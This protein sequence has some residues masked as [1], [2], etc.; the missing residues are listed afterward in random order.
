MC[1][2]LKV[3]PQSGLQE[4]LNVVHT[5]VGIA[6]LGEKVYANLALYVHNVV[7]HASLPVCSRS[8]VASSLRKGPTS[9]IELCIV[10]M[11]LGHAPPGKFAILGLL[12]SFDAISE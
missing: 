2:V 5:N 12:R 3:L 11:V 4:A 10:R 9:R 7:I 8:T 6:V 1:M